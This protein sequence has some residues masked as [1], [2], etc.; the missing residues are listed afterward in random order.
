MSISRPPEWFVH[1][2]AGPSVQVPASVAAWIDAAAD[3]GRLRQQVPHGSETH[4]VLTALL[5]LVADRQV[6]GSRAR[7][8]RKDPQ[9]A[10]N[11]TMSTT[12]AAERAGVTDSGIR[13]AIAEQRLRATKTTTGRWAITADDLASY[14]A[15]R[16]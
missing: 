14:I 10:G 9:A 15:T 6:N 3:L 4:A 8:L 11:S 7:T 2:L 16:A 1:G 13:L 5:L 12:Q